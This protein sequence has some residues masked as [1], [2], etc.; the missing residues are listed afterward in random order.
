ML[1]ALDP[2]ALFQKYADC[3][4]ED[5][6]RDR[7]RDELLDDDSRAALITNDL[8]MAILEI[9]RQ[10]QKVNSDF[11][12]A[13]PDEQLLQGTLDSS[14]ETDPN[15]A[16]FYDTNEPN[17]NQGQKTLLSEIQSSL[18]KVE[19]GGDGDLVNMDAPGGC[20]KTFLANT[21]LAYVRKQSKIGIATAMSGIAG[22]PNANSY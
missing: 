17:L 1:L 2:L 9:L 22:K 8:L 6:E 12:L 3:M 4:S 13:M 16:S 10:S 11:G 19:Q 15:A 5:F 14:A 20:G 7:S 18:E 21:V